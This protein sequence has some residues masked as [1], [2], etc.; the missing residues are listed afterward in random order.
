MILCILDFEST[1]WATVFCESDLALK[2][3]AECYKTLE[4]YLLTSSNINVFT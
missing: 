4:V 3:D 1:K 2:F